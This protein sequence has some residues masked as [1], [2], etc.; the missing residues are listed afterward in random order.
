LGSSFTSSEASI[1][2]SP[3]IRDDFLFV[4][5]HSTHSRKLH[6][7]AGIVRIHFG[8]LIIHYGHGIPRRMN[9]SFRPARQWGY[10]AMSDRFIRQ[11]LFGLD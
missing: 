6:A 9:R 3:D 5:H 4:I 8:S 7:S 1:V 10:S 2:D 11:I